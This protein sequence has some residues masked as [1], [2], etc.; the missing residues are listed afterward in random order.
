MILYH[1]TG[2]ENLEDITERG[3]VPAIGKHTETEVLN[4]SIPVVWFTSNPSPPVNG[5][6][7]A[8]R[9]RTVRMSEVGT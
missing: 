9:S 6:T 8:C 4:L 5:R 7:T 2:V 3:L 1:F